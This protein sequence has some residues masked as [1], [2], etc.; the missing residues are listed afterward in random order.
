M[1]II[2]GSKGFKDVLGQC[3]SVVE[4]G[5][6]HNEMTPKVLEV[7]KK[8]TLF[9]IPLFKTSSQHYLACPI[10]SAGLKISKEEAEHFINE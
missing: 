3:K 2:W 9:F 10:C 4:C 7:G 5:N 1:F 8:F 6:C